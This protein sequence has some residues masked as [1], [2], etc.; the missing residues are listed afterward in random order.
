VGVP[1]HRLYKWR[2][3]ARQRQNETTAVVLFVKVPR[4]LAM[5]GWAAEALT[6]S[7]VVR[8]S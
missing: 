4:E 2:R 8:F 7:V 3:A 1:A 5:N 6:H